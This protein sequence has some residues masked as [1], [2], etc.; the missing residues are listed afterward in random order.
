MVNG[1]T[2]KDWHLAT[3]ARTRALRKA[4]Y[5][6]IEKWGCQD[7]KSSEIEA[8][9]PRSK[10]RIYPHAI[11]YDFEAYMNENRRKE[12]TDTLTLTDA[13]VPISV[14]VGYTLQRQ[15]T[16]ICEREPA[17][18]I[19]KFVEEVEG[20]GA[21]IRKR[22]RA[23]FLPKDIEL[24]TKKPRKRIE[25][26]CNQ[27]PVLGFNSGKYDLNLIK[28]HF[29][30]QLADTTAKIKVAKKGNTTMFIQTPHFHFLDIVNYVG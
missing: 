13:H 14:S 22:V 30:E 27:V 17:D 29:A 7:A 3:L 10:T 2:G 11:F 25:E 23:E 12:R 6:V 20:R 1:K 18:L 19:R 16:H 5:R 9:I 8:E 28:R 21:E 4:D 24:V 15:P 26:W